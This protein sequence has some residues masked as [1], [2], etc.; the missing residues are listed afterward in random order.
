MATF[1]WL[2]WGPQVDS[3]K[4]N[5]KAH[6]QETEKLRAPVAKH[7]REFTKTEAERNFSKMSQVTSQWQNRQED[8]SDWKTDR[9][10]EGRRGVTAATD[11]H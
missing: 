2:R 9:G 1:Y 7:N 4:K 3:A 11:S 8:E 10:N 5:I 6:Q